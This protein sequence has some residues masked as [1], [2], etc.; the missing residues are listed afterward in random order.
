MR[1]FWKKFSSTE[2]WI[3][4]SGATFGTVM[5]IV[6]TIGVT[7]WQQMRNQEE[8]TR[9]IAKITLHNIDVRVNNLSEL[10]DFFTEKDSIFGILQSYMPDSLDK[11]DKD[12][13]DFYMATLMY[14]TF[15]AYDTKSED[16]FSSSFEVWQFLDNEKVIGR[17]S[18]CYSALNVCEQW[19]TEINEN[20]LEFSKERFVDAVANDKSFNSVEFVKDYLQ[21]PEVC[22]FYRNLVSVSIGHNVLRTIQELNDYNKKVLGL[23]QA[24]LDDLGNLLGD[25][26]SHRYYQMEKDSVSQVCD[27]LT[28]DS[29][30]ER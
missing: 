9:K 23:N 28:H 11:I 10:F 7:Y 21:N 30:P 1:N 14:R 2:W 3:N 16:I 8:M 13:L 20:F 6:L 27:T 12:T 24:E 29:L 26:S 18:N 17:I 25:N 19:I 15:Q 22:Y 5:G 4:A